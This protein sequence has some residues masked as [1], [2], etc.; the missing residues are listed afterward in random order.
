MTH[1]FSV[2]CASDNSYVPNCVVSLL[3]FKKFNPQFDMFIIGSKFSNDIFSLCKHFNIKL[4]EINLSRFFHTHWD[5]PIECYYHFRAPIIFNKL[6]YQFSVYIDGD[7]YCNNKFDVN[8]NAITHLS[9]VGYFTVKYFLQRI[10]KYNVL[11]NKLD[12][13]NDSHFQRRHIQTG[14]IVYNNPN[15]VDFNFF[16]QIVSLYNSSIR[17]NIPRK[18]DDSLLALFI[19]MSPQLHVKYIRKVYNFINRETKAFLSMH[20]FLIHS[21][22]IYHLNSFKPWI[23]DSHNYPNFTYKFF[24]EKWRECMINLFSQQ[25]IHRYFPSFYKK[26]LIHDNQIKFFWFTNSTPNFGDWITPYLVN[27]ISSLSLSKPT[28]PNLTK[29]IV[30]LSTGSILRLSSHNTIVWGSGIRDRKQ[31]VKASK[32]F[33]SVRGPLTRKR[34]LELRYEC[35]PIYGDPGLLLP[36]FYNPSN[37]EK[38]YTLGII[39]HISQFERVYNLYKFD[40]NILILD[41]RT[42]D[43]EFIINQILSCHKCISSSLHGII[44]SNAYNVPVRWIKFDDNI[45]GDDTKYYDHFFAI[46]RNNE[47]FINAQPYVHIPINLLLNAITPYKIDI[48]LDRLM[49]NSFFSGHKISKYFKYIL[50]P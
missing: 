11:L 13:S 2:F 35:P 20:S 49:E 50:S 47:T 27:K 33:R 9:G 40:K 14:V 37:I 48:D 44:V 18:G 34:L 30:F 3:S 45:K 25:Q 32:L 39:P 28:D 43:I 21:C 29:F 1:K 8:W 19:A 42:T 24:T 46:N 26:N 12:I 5:Y 16:H 38:I 4:L 36:R 41:L 17:L 7:V 6:G 31:S 10:D 23:N 22:V 15:L